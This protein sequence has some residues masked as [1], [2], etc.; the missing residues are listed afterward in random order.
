MTTYK[1]KSD[2]E[3]LMKSFAPGD[4][5]GE[6]FVLPLR[7]GPSISLKRET[8]SVYFALGG[9][10]GYPAPPVF[11]V[12]SPDEETLSLY[13]SNGKRCKIVEDVIITKEDGTPVVQWSEVL[14]KVS[15]TR[16][17]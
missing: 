4:Y 17:S 7:D 12:W 2:V 8:A 5:N 1:T 14:R 6:S 3:S 11:G 13:R 16:N 10:H 15:L 9:T